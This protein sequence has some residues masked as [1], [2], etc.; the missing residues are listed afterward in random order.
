VNPEERLL[1][2][3]VLVTIVTAYLIRD[4]GSTYFSPAEWEAAAIHS[5]SLYF[6][7]NDD[8]HPMLVALMN[9]IREVQ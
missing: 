8:E 6:N 2:H 1:E 5:G 3:G 4:G 9:R 7:R